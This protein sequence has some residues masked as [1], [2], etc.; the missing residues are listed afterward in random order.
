MQDIFDTLKDTGN[1]DEVEP[2]ITALTNYFTPKKN[3][4]YETLKFREL[5]QHA[6]ESIDQFCTRLRKEAPRCEF[7]DEARVEREIKTQILAKYKNKYVRTRALEKERTL[8]QL[9]ELIRNLELSEARSNEISQQQASG[10]HRVEQRRGTRS[11]RT[12]LCYNCGY[13]WP[14]DGECPAA[15]K[16]CRRCGKMNH[17]AQ[18]CNTSPRTHTGETV[19]STSRSKASSKGKYTGEKSKESYAA[20]K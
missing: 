1:D 17:F 7:G 16:E 13:P 15:G 6:G 8:D 18:C 4:S 14:H 9:L 3:I 10:V 12:T 2:A 5:E 11:D 19:S 20:R